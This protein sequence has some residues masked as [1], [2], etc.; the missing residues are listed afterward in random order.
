MWSRAEVANKASLKM[1]HSVT[2]R[3]SRGDETDRAIQKVLTN[4]VNNVL[5]GCDPDNN[6]NDDPNLT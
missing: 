6:F 3:M 5:T 4:L 1:L 2:R